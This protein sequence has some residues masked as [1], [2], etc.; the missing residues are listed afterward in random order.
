MVRERD[1]HGAELRATS[2]K[3]LKT[4]GTARVYCK[5]K[6]AVAVPFSVPAALLFDAQRRSLEESANAILSTRPEDKLGIALDLRAKSIQSRKGHS[7][8]SA[9]AAPGN[10]DTSQFIQAGAPDRS[11]LRQGFRAF[12]ANVVEAQVKISESWH[13]RQSALRQGC[14][15]F[16]ANGVVPKIELSELR[17]ARQSSLRQGFRA[18]SANGVPGKAELS[19]PRHARQSSL[20]QG[21]RAF[22][23]NGVVPKV[24]LSE[25]R[26]A[27]QSSL[28]QGFR[29]FSA[30][31]VL[32][33]AELSELRHTRQSSLRQ[34]S[35]AFSAH[36]VA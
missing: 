22:R 34:G 3:N 10:D 7:Q 13:A 32:G 24:E 35:R 33:K 4:L 31:G 14:R 2:K 18:F 27:R 20:R 9:D 8:A 12:I 26:H 30:N 23:A 29:A 36:E 16:S 6:K 5:R 17:H 25:L 15:A 21:F 1:K 11:R 28:R 19:E